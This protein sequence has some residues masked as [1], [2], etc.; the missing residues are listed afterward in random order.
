MAE[1]VNSHSCGQSTHLRLVGRQWVPSPGRNRPQPN[2]VGPPNG[3]C[4]TIRMRVG[5]PEVD[6]CLVKPDA[7]P[8]VQPQVNHRPRRRHR[9][10]HA[11]VGHE[12]RTRRRRGH[13]LGRSSGIRPADGL[14]L[15]IGRCLPC[16]R[17]QEREHGYRTGNT[18][19]ADPFCSGYPLSFQQTHANPHW[20][21][22]L[23]IN[24]LGP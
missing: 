14:P 3:V 20:V 10:P 12:P 13:R 19:V 15:G 11:V 23:R 24:A 6:T 4:W 17:H 18:R 1:R 16:V 2:R 8:G 22:H 9:D 7:R 21:V 5:R